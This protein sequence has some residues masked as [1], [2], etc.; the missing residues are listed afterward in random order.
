MRRRCEPQADIGLLLD[1]ALADNA[2][3]E[4]YLDKFPDWSQPILEWLLRAD[5]L[6]ALAVGSVVLFVLS[7]IGVPWFIAQMPEDY[8]VRS[9]TRDHRAWWRMALMIGKN[10]VGMVLLFAGIA[11]LVLP[12]QGLLAIFVSLFFLDFPGKR[13]LELR[14]IEYPPIFRTLNKLRHRAGRPP[15]QRHAK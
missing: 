3:V 1:L 13:R 15:L 11:M 10:L 8:F 6:L 7:I 2:D 14:L 9:H 5:V 12:G 4:P